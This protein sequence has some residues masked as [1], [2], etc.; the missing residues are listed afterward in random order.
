MDIF[1]EKIKKNLDELKKNIQNEI[2]DYRILKIIKFKHGDCNKLLPE[3][4]LHNNISQY[5][6]CLVFL[7]PEGP[8]LYWDTIISLAKIKKVD[9]LILYPYD[10]SLVRLTKDYPEKLDKFYGTPGWLDIFSKRNNPT[11]AREKLLKFYINNLKKLG[12]QYTTYRQIRRGFREGKP[13]YH[14]IL[15]TRNYAGEKIMKD[16]FDKELDNQKK[17]K[18]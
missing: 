2:T 7:D 4:N 14:L 18:F 3:F 15:A 5:S 8:E 9:L 10:M 16:I 1:I 11:D 17:F 12:F 13:L 6:G